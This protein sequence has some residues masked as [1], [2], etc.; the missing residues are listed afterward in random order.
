MFDKEIK[1]WYAV[2]NEYKKMT[3]MDKTFYLTSLF[4]DIKTQPW[5]ATDIKIALN[6]IKKLS[7]YR[8]YIP[9]L[10]DIENFKGDIDNKINS[11]PLKMTISKEELL[12]ILDINRAHI[13]RETN[14]IVLS[15]HNRSI[16]NSHELSYDKQTKGLGGISWFEYFNHGVNGGL[17]F[18][19]TRTSLKILIVMIKYT[20]LN[21]EIID[22][23]K[24]S[25]AV[26]TFV[27]I[28]IIKDSSKK[29]THTIDIN[30]YKD[31]MGLNGKYKDINLLRSRVLDVVKREICEKTDM[32]MNYELVKEGRSFTKIKFIFDYKPEHVDKK[33]KSQVKNLKEPTIIENTVTDDYDSPFEQILI[34]WNIRAKKVVE[35]EEN[36][37]LD[38]IQSAIDK[39]L[40]KEKA[41][42]IKTTK[43]AIFLGILEN[44]QL[45]SDEQ[46]ERTKKEFEQKQ[47]K[48]LREKISAEYDLIHSFIL[49]NQDT[50]QLALTTNTKYLPITDKEAISVFKKLKNIDADKFRVYTVPILSFYHFESN[51]NVSSILSDVVD[52]SQ[53]IEIEEYNDDME[54]IKAYKK[55]LINI[56]ANEYITDEQKNT[57]RKEVQ[58]SINILRLNAYF[59]GLTK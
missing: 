34:S 58:D 21:I 30:E 26:L 16:I 7:A 13:A 6:I 8:C 45:A 17:E 15:M 27:F 20:Q 5:S 41:G 28:K 18:S 57:L 44:K 52:R 54:I 56:K 14:K 50:I 4:T 9:R 2:M 35:I 48:K 25:Y 22:K 47:D 33:N 42:E 1:F 36:Y 19:F 32:D 12:N 23:I 37:S 29:N 51:S 24:N 55:A 43:A 31:K 11:V 49:S 38:V 53:Y 39:T 40:E 59:R 3:Y 10:E 46:F